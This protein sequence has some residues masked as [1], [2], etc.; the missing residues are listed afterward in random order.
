MMLKLRNRVALGDIESIRVD[1]FREAWSATGERVNPNKWDPKTREMA[2]K[3]LPYALAVAL[4]DGAVNVESFTDERINDPRLRP[5]MDLISI[6][7]SP[8]F[9]ARLP[10]ERPSAISIRLHSGQVVSE[11]TAHPFGH[12]E[13]PPSDDELDDKFESLSRLSTDDVDAVR[14]IRHMVWRFESLDEVRDLCDALGRLV[15]R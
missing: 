9:M 5:V 14:R 15:I 2:D 7:L 11:Q 4:V 12:P 1:T 8:E 3:S 13:N 10:Q 6:Y